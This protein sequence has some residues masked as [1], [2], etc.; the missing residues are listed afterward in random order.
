[1]VSSSQ[2]DLAVNVLRNGTSLVYVH[3]FT[4]RLSKDSTIPKEPFLFI[5]LL[6]I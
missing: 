3:G 1:M 2:F 6:I 4:K 5:I